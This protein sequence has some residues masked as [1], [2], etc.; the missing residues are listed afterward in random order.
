MPAVWTTTTLAQRLLLGDGGGGIGDMVVDGVGALANAPRVPIAWCP[1]PMLPVL[2]VVLAEALDRARQTFH[3]PH[4]FLLHLP[5]LPQTIVERI[6][7][8][9]GPLYDCYSRAGPSGGGGSGASGASSCD[10]GRACAL[11]AVVGNGQSV[12]SW[13]RDAGLPMVLES[14]DCLVAVLATM[15]TVY[16][17]VHIYLTLMAIT[18]RGQDLLFSSLP[19]FNS[20]DP[21]L[22][23]QHTRR[24]YD[25]H[26]HYCQHD[27][28]GGAA[29]AAAAAAAWKDLF[30]NGDP[31]ALVATAGDGTV[32]V[33][34]TAT[35][36]TT[37]AEAAAA[38]VDGEFSA[39][40][41]AQLRRR[42]RRMLCAWATAT[43]TGRR[44]RR[45]DD[46]AAAA[47][48]T[49]IVQDPASQDRW[50]TGRTRRHG[51]SGWRRSTWTTAG[52]ESAVAHAST[53]STTP[54][55]T[56]Q[57][58]PS[59]CSLPSSSSSVSTSSS[60]TTTPTMLIPCM[61]C[62]EDNPP[63]GEYIRCCKAIVHSRC[64]MEW[65]SM[66]DREDGTVRC[67]HCCRTEREIRRVIQYPGHNANDAK[68]D[69]NDDDLR[70]GDIFV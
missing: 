42:V 4:H 44:R 30:C 33:T 58:D 9:I 16:M 26:R 28:D 51:G 11:M 63:P 56:S 50:T 17:T 68:D 12:W 54:S 59:V 32:T 45:R 8:S 46:A 2:P 43:T 60:S 66:L 57:C 1:V 34:I 39:G 5:T 31:C 37:A 10:G 61:I 15:F 20:D 18:E 29:A 6:H 21:L 3:L 35:T 69:A 47:A 23:Q 25:Y 64:C 67:P 70:I 36:M 38:G 24:L 14:L 40:N 27:S 48:A 55:T 41:A 22:H 62:R 7:Q 19:L 49:T 52:Q 65:W 53:T 13:V